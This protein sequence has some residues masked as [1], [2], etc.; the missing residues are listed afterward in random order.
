MIIGPCAPAR[1]V[2]RSAARAPVSAELRGSAATGST[3]PGSSC[4]HS[5]DPI[6]TGPSETD[7]RWQSTTVI[8]TVASGCQVADAVC[9]PFGSQERA[10][11]EDLFHLVAAPRVQAGTE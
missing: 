9:G 2:S 8:L 6:F 10:S 3:K 7:G 5:R 1:G 4:R 11:Q